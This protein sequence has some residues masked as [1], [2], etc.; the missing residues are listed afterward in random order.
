M[1]ARMR[2]LGNTWQPVSAQEEQA[3]LQVLLLFYQQIVFDKVLRLFYHRR[4]AVVN[5]HLSSNQS[6]PLEILDE[7]ASIVFLMS[8]HICGLFHF[9]PE[10][11]L[12]LSLLVFSPFGLT[13]LILFFA[14]GKADFELNMGAFSIPGKRNEGQ[15]GAFYPS[16]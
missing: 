13:L 10:F 16:F 6:S 11:P 5:V 14:F 8:A 1:L 4:L 2:K 9:P 7:S 12:E 3:L 15:I